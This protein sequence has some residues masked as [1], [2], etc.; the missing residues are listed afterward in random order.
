MVEISNLAG[1]GRAALGLLIDIDP[2]C[3]RQILP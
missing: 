2:A 3:R 1:L